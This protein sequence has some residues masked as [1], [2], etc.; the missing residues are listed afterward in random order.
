[1][2]DKF[3]ESIVK[4]IPMA[5]AFY[6]LICDENE[7]PINYKFLEVNEAFEQITGFKADFVIG[8]KI[9]EV[10]KTIKTDDFD[11]INFYGDIAINNKRET[12]ERYIAEFGRWY[13]VIA[14]SPQKYY[15]AICFV[16][17]TMEKEKLVELKNFFDVNLDLLCIASLDGKFER[18]NREWERMLEYK[19]EEIVGKYFFDFL[20]EEDQERTKEAIANLIKNKKIYNFINKYRTRSGKYRTIEWRAK[21]CEDKIFAAS[22]DITDRIEIERLKE[23][24]F[25]KFHKLFDNNPALMAVCDLET[26]E[27]YDVNNSFCEVLG[28]EDVELI[29]KSTCDLGIF[30][31][32]KKHEYIINSLRHNSRIGNI[33]LEIKKKDNNIITGLFSAEIIKGY[34][35]TSYMMVIIDITRQKNIENKLILKDKI[36]SAVAK[37]TQVLLDSMD[38]VKAL[39]SCFAILGRALEVDRVY[40]FRNYYDEEGNGYTSQKIE[41][42]AND[43]EPQ[44]DNPMLQNIPFS[45][46]ESFME[47]LKNKHSFYGEVKNFKE[48]VRSILEAQGILSIIVMPIIINNKFWGFMGFD[49]CKYE[50]KWDEI[51]F[52]T[53]SVFRNSLEMAIERHLIEESLKDSKKQA[54]K[55]NIAKSQF[56]ANMSHEIRT[57]INGIVGM[58]N[59]LD[60]TSLSNEQK[61]YV[62]EAQNASKILLHLINDVLDI[63]KIEAGKMV[64]EKTEFD[65]KKLVEETVSL[66][67]P[68]AK[69]KKVALNLFIE[70]TIPNIVIGDLAKVKQILN[71]LLSNAI[72]FTD[73]GQITVKVECSKNEDKKTIINFEVKDTGIGM[74]EDELNKIFNPFEQA[75]TSTTRKYGGTGLGLSI[76]NELVSMMNGEFKVESKKGKGSTFEFYLEFEKNQIKNN[77]NIAKNNKVY[78]NNNRVRNNNKQP[79]ILLVEDNEINLKV[80]LKILDKEGYKCDIAINGKEGYE[81]YIENDYDI[82]FMDCQMP[83]MDGYEATRKIREYE[84]NHKKHVKIVAMTAYAMEEDKNKCF[85]SGMDEYLSKPINFKKLLEILSNLELEEDK[86]T[87]ESNIYLEA[88]EAFKEETGLEEDDIKELYDEFEVLYEDRIDKLKQAIENNNIEKISNLAHDIKGA[89]SNLKIE[90]INKLS[91]ELEIEAKNNNYEGC[92]LKILKLENLIK[93]DKVK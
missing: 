5:Y 92:K 72:K 61:S 10:V 77:T 19:N 52:S 18:I 25:D 50:R 22:R 71:N 27:F 6:E 74:N 4:N 58:L 86:K 26:N 45:D 43:I 79:K 85:V 14:F 38:Y 84:S 37:S 80:I 3:Y 64:L 32:T 57:P 66:F 83:V 54:E 1:M 15:F 49:E 89:S 11:W 17:I 81:Y 63:S 20:H 53:L 36:L 28:Y 30:Q 46:V 51:E 48:N 23:N 56:L 41:W 91:K 82:I 47:P 75:D 68:K 12:I 2:K 31:D 42:N 33:E 87:N 35:E 55:A 90:E 40:L 78:K 9:T 24:A 73:E 29:G 8:K 44:I 69:E 21:I 60:Y 16:D 65:I 67:M 70:Y 62:K 93:K 59:L 13:Q 39:E 76:S 88:K 34:K 7:K